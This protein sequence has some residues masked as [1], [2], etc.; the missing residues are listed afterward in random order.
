MQMAAQWAD[1]FEPHYL[2]FSMRP[3]QGE[4]LRSCIKACLEAERLKREEFSDEEARENR[5]LFAELEAYMRLLYRE[6]IRPNQPPDTDWVALGLEPMLKPWLK[7]PVPPPEAKPV[8]RFNDRPKNREGEIVP[9][10][11]RTIRM[12][13]EPDVEPAAPWGEKYPRHV[14]GSVLSYLEYRWGI[15]PPGSVRGR[16]AMADSRLLGVVPDDVEMLRVFFTERREEHEFRFP[17]ED[18][19]KTLYIAG[20]YVNDE[21]V[22]GPCGDIFS[23]V[24]P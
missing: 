14:R 10:D 21:G 2:R 20:R 23:F 22:D 11:S 8:L 9:P 18:A 6:H 4:A 7:R 15:L 24:I 13:A 16:D 3:E 19:G 12:R 17:P 5:R 1:Y